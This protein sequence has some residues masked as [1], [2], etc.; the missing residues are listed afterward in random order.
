MQAATGAA[1][2]GVVTPVKR[3]GGQNVVKEISDACETLGFDNPR[4]QSSALRFFNCCAG[5][6]SVVEPLHCVLVASKINEEVLF[7]MRDVDDHFPNFKV[8]LN[9][10][11]LFFNAPV[12]LQLSKYVEAEKTIFR[13]MDF[14]LF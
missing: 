4:T 9:S 12:V 7:D 14:C 11:S 10:L 2:R 1:R 5:V 6:A 8:L 3:R 13:V